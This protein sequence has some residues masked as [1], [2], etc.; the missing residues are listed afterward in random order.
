MPV[1]SNSREKTVVYLNARKYIMLDQQQLKEWARKL[2]LSEQ[3][4]SVIIK[5]GPLHRLV[6]WVAAQEMSVADIRAKRWA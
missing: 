2:N 1:P 4:E 3:A 6:V 5:S